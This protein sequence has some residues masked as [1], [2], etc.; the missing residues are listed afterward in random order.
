MLSGSFSRLRGFSHLAVSTSGFAGRKPR[1]REKSSEKPP[2]IRRM[3]LAFLLRKKGFDAK[4]SLLNEKSSQKSFAPTPRISSF[5][6]REKMI[7]WLRREKI[8]SRR[9]ILQKVARPRIAVFSL[10]LR[11]RAGNGF[12]KNNLEGD[13]LKSF[14]S[15]SRVSFFAAQKTG[16]RFLSR[17]AKHALS[18]SVGEAV[19][20]RRRQDIP[21]DLYLQGFLLTRPHFSSPK[22]NKILALPSSRRRPGSM[23]RKKSGSVDSD[24][25]RNDRV[26]VFFCWFLGSEKVRAG[27]GFLVLQSFN[28]YVK[29]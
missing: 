10:L 8:A 29:R 11:K 18:A 5:R 1:S 14:S 3:P 25:R 7:A 23:L 26:P 9:K 15:P 6:L 12:L 13:P 17:Y 27:Q 24:L 4:K 22:T 19:G 16:E 2:P 28:F 21:E 20:E